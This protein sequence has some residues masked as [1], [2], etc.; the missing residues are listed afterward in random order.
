MVKWRILTDK[1]PRAMPAIDLHT[2]SIC[3]DGALTPS[4]LVA[5]AHAAGV[6]VLA[7]TDH[8]SVIGVPEATAAAQ[9]CGMTLLPGLELSTL[10]KSF[11]IHIVGLGVDIYHEGLV[12]GLA[13]QAAARGERAK[14][15]AVR[16]EKAK[17]PGAY[18]AALA[19][20]GGDPDRISRTHFAQW[21]KE[22]GAVSS[23]Q[24]AFDKYLG[25]GKPADVPMP[26]LDLP[27]AVRLIKDAGGTAILAH[28][29][30]YPLTRTKLRALIELFK[31]AGGEALE[32][33][34]ATEKPDVVRYLGQLCTQYNMEASQGSDFHG[35][36]VPWIQLGRFPELPAECRPV[37]RRWI[38]EGQEA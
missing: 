36:H 3:S 21:L 27:S 9:A 2:H 13:L 35:P 23:M 16:L 25:N 29:G 10:W 31:E 11:S 12:A 30:R 22:T 17:R 15:I 24:G 34:T 33:A 8:D 28:P 6:K 14:A 37:W 38:P 5:R 19:L 7:L 18:E 26:W 20:A 4:D 1:N 32:V